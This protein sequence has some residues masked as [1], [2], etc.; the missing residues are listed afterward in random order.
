MNFSIAMIIIIIISS[1]KIIITI[2]IIIIIIITIANII[3][4]LQWH[5]NGRDS[6]LNHQPHDCSL[7]RLFRR[8]SKK[9]PKFRVT[10]FCAGNSPVTGEF[11]A[12]MASYVENVSISWRHHGSYF[13]V[14]L[15]DIVFII[16][17][18]VHFLILISLLSKILLSVNYQNRSSANVA[19]GWWIDCL[20]L[21]NSNITW[22][23]VS[24]SRNLIDEKHFPVESP[25]THLDLVG[26]Y[27]LSHYLS[28]SV[29]SSFEPLWTS[30]K[31]FFLSKC[32]I[33]FVNCIRKI[34]CKM[35]AIYSPSYSGCNVL[36]KLPYWYPFWQTGT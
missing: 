32:Y 24:H 35:S 9:T 13:A 23:F 16:S 18:L 26:T 3:I 10:R 2:I 8:R 14:V 19:Q 27:A 28:Q 22:C 7:N 15:V 17:L 4:E 33:F 34:I 6:V 5:H 29:S 1:N 20:Y 12:Q 36:T 25:Y 30:F 21:D 31:D 11:P